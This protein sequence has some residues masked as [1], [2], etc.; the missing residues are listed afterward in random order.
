MR[1][2]WISSV[3]RAARR[4]TRRVA[5]VVAGLRPSEPTKW[6]SAA[7]KPCPLVCFSQTNNQITLPVELVPFREKRGSTGGPGWFGPNPSG[8]GSAAPP[9]R[10]SPNPST[11]T[12]TGR[13]IQS[14]RMLL[15]LW[16]RSVREAVFTTPDSQAVL[17]TR[18]RG[19]RLD[20]AAFCFGWMRPRSTSSSAICTALS[21]A[22]LR[23]LSETIHIDSPFSMVGSSRM[24]EMKVASSPAESSGVT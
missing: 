14:N 15:Q 2:D 24:R 17:P 1:L 12:I 13:T 6:A 8:F 18:G 20:Q 11:Q 21:A 10:P 16:G 22:P 19:V 3:S 7:R 5:M 4:S 23:R 9:V